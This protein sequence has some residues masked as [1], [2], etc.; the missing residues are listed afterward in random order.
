MVSSEFCVHIY[1]ANILFIAENLHN[2]LDQS[3]VCASAQL[4]CLYPI[5]KTEFS[6]SNLCIIPKICDLYTFIALLLPKAGNAKL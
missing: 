3:E 1:I 5:H 4:I 2:I 6:H